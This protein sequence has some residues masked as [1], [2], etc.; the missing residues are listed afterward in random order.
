MPPSTTSMCSVVSVPAAAQTAHLSIHADAQPGTPSKS[1]SQ[2]AVAGQTMLQLV[3]PEQA[4]P[5]RCHIHRRLTC[6]VCCV[7]VC[8]LHIHQVLLVWSIGMSSS[9]TCCKTQWAV[10]S[11]RCVGTLA[12]RA[13]PR[14]ASWGAGSQPTKQSRAS[15][16][17]HCRTGRLRSTSR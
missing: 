15:S 13:G 17:T 5:A 4:P 3:I 14:P 9:M 8:C 2:V 7:H 16:S 10:A 1:C 6:C 12:G 11:Q